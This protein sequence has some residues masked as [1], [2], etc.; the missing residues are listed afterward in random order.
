VRRFSLEKAVIIKYGG[1]RVFK[2]QKFSHYK[3]L[4]QV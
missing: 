1:G 4:Y 2:K 3:K